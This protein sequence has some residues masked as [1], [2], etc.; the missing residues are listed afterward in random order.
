[1]LKN[2]LF[3]SLLLILFLGVNSCKSAQ[4]EQDKK[5]GL[6][7]PNNISAIQG[8]TKSVAFTK[9]LS[10]NNANENNANQILVKNEETLEGIYNQ[11][12][13][14]QFPGEKIPEIDF[15]KEMVL[16]L[17]MGGKSTGGHGVFIERVVA[18]STE[19]IVFYK[20][21]APKGMATSVLTQP[22]YIASIAKTDLPIRFQK[23]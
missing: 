20:E 15:E 10:G 14:T 18:T 22:F 5:S 21:T 1:M 8:A 11:I 19:I 6:S 17:Y 9:L 23:L 12:N 16:V 2:L 7:T 13:S 4:Q 3:S